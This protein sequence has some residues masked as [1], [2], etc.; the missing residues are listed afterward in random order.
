MIF[1]QIMEALTS[2]TRFRPFFRGKPDQGDF[3]LACGLLVTAF[4]VDNIVTRYLFAVGNPYS[5]L[6]LLFFVVPRSSMRACL[7]RSAAEPMYLGG[8]ASRAR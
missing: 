8:L 4:L 1:V 5:L 7:N 2:L 6:A 3:Y